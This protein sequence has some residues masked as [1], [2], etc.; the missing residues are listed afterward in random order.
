MCSGRGLYTGGG[1]LGFVAV[2]AAVC[3]ML[4]KLLTAESISSGD[5][6]LTLS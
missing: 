3:I 2:Q 6:N 5:F 1:K 4:V